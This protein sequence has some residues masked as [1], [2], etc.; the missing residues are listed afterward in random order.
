MATTALW[1]PNQAEIAQVETYTFTAPSSVGNTYNA[2]INGKTITY[3]SVSGDTAASVATALFNLLNDTTSIAT[4]FTEIEFANPS[5]GVVT[6]TARTPGVPFANVTINGVAGNGL[7]LSTG[8]GLTG[9]ISTSHTTANNSSNDAGDLQNWLRINLSVTP[10]TQIRQL[11]QNGDDVVIADSSVSL[12]WNLDHLSSIQFNTYT[13]WQTFTGTIG[14]PQVNDAGYNEWRAKYFKISGPTG[15]VPSGG[16]VMILGYGGTSTGG[17][18]GREKYDV[19]SQPCTLS[20]VAS[21][22]AIDEYGIQ[23]LG[24]H[25]NNTINIIGAASLGVAM[26]PGEKCNL[27]SVTVNQGATLGIGANVTFSAGSSISSYGGTLVLN[28]A[29]AT[30]NLYN[31]SQS[32]ILTDQLTWTT[33]VSQGG[34]LLTMLAGGTITTLTMTTSSILDKS[35]D[36]RALTITNSTIDGDTCSIN[37][38]LNTITFTNATSVKQSVTTG[39]FKFTGTRTVKVT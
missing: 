21:G 28:A 22:N 11:P 4:E 39:P 35:Q 37:D 1:S 27:L 15:S 13:R 34:S 18:P 5:S 2:T 29:P 10:P 16:L 23:F 17:G 32:R 7:V 19:G 25:T 12:L 6:A 14:L 8:N 3:T 38:P 24:Q 9:G 33:I 26:N 36:G 31:G 20:V 30:L